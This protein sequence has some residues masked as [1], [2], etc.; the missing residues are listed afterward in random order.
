MTIKVLDEIS[1][2]KISAGEVVERPLNVVKEL[3]ENALDAGANT[4]SVEIEKS[5][6]RLIR[7]CDNG[8]GMSKEDLIACIKR[9]ATSKISSFDDFQAA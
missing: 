7:V 5:G 1:I 8:I 3:L 4:V 6:K 2:N 9:H